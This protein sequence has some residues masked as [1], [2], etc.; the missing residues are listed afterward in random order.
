MSWDFSTEPEFEAKL[1]WIRTFVRE[2][3]EPLD[4]LF[5]GYEY[6]PL[7]EERRRIVDPLKQRVREQGPCGRRISAPNSAGRVSVR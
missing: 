7:N 2:E 3:V 1:D 6:V 5:P 4:A